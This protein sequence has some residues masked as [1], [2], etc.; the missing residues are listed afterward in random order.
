MPKEYNVTRQDFIERLEHLKNREYDN[1]KQL[2][3]NVFSCC[4]ERPYNSVFNHVEF[5]FKDYNFESCYPLVYPAGY[6]GIIL[7]WDNDRF[8]MTI[9]I[10]SHKQL[11]LDFLDYDNYCCSFSKDISWEKDKSMIEFCL[12]LFSGQE[13]NI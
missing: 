8:C 13:G 12:F 4:A 10:N 2:A 7:E 3:D 9:E 5:L 6:G 11:E 1:G